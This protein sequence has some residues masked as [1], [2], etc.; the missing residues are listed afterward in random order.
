M[1]WAGS[2]EGRCGRGECVEQGL[3]ITLSKSS[4]LGD[5]GSKEE[6]VTRSKQWCGCGLGVGLFHA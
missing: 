3:A 4:E 1:V 6:L 2:E 5:R